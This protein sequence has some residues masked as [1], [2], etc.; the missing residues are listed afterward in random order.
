MSLLDPE[1]IDRR[2]VPSAALPKG[3][4]RREKRMTQKKEARINGKLGNKSMKSERRR[5]NAISN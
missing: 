1:V 2:Q 3:P 4:T 5:T